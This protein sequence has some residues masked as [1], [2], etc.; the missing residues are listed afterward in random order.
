M[1]TFLGKDLISSMMYDPVPPHTGKNS[2]ANMHR[3]RF[4]IIS[5]A[6]LS[7]NI[8]SLKIHMAADSVSSNLQV[9]TSCAGAKKTKGLNCV[10]FF[11]NANYN[12]AYSLKTCQI[13]YGIC[14]FEISSCKNAH[15][16][17]FSPVDTF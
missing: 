10:T 11:G 7:Y 9:F 5:P 8:G 1:L 6:N 13:F 14:R 17:D 4:S 16:D 15:G 12:A 3:V 2:G